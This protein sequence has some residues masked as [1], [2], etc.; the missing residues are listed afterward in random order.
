MKSAV[1]ALSAAAKPA[2]QSE[3]N[4]IENNTYYISGINVTGT[5]DGQFASEFM[6]L[7]K[8]YGRLAKT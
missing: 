4:R 6:D 8:R 7:M 5:S 3:T 2:A 1:A